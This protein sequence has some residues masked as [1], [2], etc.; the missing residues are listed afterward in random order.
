V[1]RTNVHAPA[2]R[3]VDPPTIVVAPTGKIERVTE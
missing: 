1:R 2:A 3:Y